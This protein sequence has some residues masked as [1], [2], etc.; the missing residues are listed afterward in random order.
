MEV[1][2]YAFLG[3]QAVVDV[4]KTM[5]IRVR[6]AYHLF[7]LLLLFYQQLPEGLVSNNNAREAGIIH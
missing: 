5:P 1:I 3:G 6:L 7:L 4:P 2:G